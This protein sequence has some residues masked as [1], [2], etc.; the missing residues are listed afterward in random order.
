MIKKKV[1]Y[2]INK[3]M[4]IEDFLNICSKHY[5]ICDPF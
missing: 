4:S 3:D 2:N 1:V 5:K